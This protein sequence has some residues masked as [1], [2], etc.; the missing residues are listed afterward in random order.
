MAASIISV[1]KT[2]LDLAVNLQ[3][4]GYDVHKTNVE[5]TKIIDIDDDIMDSLNTLMSKMNRN[6]QSSKKWVEN[7]SGELWNC[8]IPWQIPITKKFCKTSLKPLASVS[9]E[10]SSVKLSRSKSLESLTCKQQRTRL[11]AV[12]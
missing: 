5:L 8:E 3:R 10:V 6:I 1:P 9:Q 4:V 2:R 11:A 12:I 7:I